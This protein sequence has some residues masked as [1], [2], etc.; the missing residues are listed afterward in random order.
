[1]LHGTIC[2]VE[3]QLGDHFMGAGRDERDE[4]ERSFPITLIRTRNHDQ[5]IFGIEAELIGSGRSA[6]RDEVAAAGGTPQNILSGDGVEDPPLPW[7]ISD[8]KLGH[9]A[10]ALALVRPVPLPLPPMH[11]Q[12]A[13]GAGDGV[14]TLYAS[15]T[16]VA[17]WFLG[18]VSTWI[19][20]FDFVVAAISQ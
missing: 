15:K 9:T 11:G 5:M 17:D 7:A 6:D 12:H 2:T 20:D 8:P 18:G 1:G 13:I 10:R 14:G 4:G 19:D 16:P 3:G